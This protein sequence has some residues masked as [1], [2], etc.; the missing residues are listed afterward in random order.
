M[1]F[2]GKVA[3]WFWGIFVIGNVL[4]LRELIF[5]RDNLPA[6]VIGIVTFELVFLPILLRNYVLLESDSVT[7]VFGI[8][9]DTIKIS[10]IIEVYQTHNPIASSAAS[11]DRIVIKGR[12]QEIICAVQEKQRFLEELEKRRAPFDYATSR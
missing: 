5:S 2:K 6:L 4:F 12:R 9:K 7:V 10:D 11:L 8:G 3:A 1:K